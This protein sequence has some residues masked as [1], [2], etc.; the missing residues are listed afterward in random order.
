VTRR[1]T[2]ATRARVSRVVDAS[3]GRDFRRK[4]S[5]SAR[6]RGR[7]SIS[8]SASKRASGVKPTERSYVIEPFHAI[9]GSR[10]AR[11][12]LHHRDF[13]EMQRVDRDGGGGVEAI[14]R[15]LERERRLHAQIATELE[16]AEAAYASDLEVRAMKSRKLRLKDA[17]AALERD[18]VRA[19]ETAEVLGSGAY[20]RIFKAKD[21][22]TG[23]PVA[24]KVVDV[25]DE[26]A[27]KAEF[28]LLRTLSADDSRCFPKPL[29][30][31]R[32]TVMGQKARVMVMNLL[33]ESLEQ[34]SQ[35]VTMGT[36]FSRCTTARVAKRLFTALEACHRNCV[37][38][39]D[40]KPDNLLTE[41]HVGGA[42]RNGIVLVDFGEAIRF[43]DDDIARLDEDVSREDWR[44]T[45]LFSSPNVDAGAKMAP[46]DDLESAI[47]T[48][49]YLR[50]G[51][52]PWSRALDTDEREVD[53]RELAKAKRAV[54]SGAA[55]LTPFGVDDGRVPDD[56]EDDVDFFERVLSHA[57][58]LRAADAPDYD[59]LQRSVAEWRAGS[60]E[61]YEWE[62]DP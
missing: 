38:H 50:T 17:V 13:E 46:R 42:R 8:A 4:M 35:R 9:L 36:G 27:L 51:R 53:V 6:T 57:R 14:E 30:C 23:E 10:K 45:L 56:Y 28:S 37:V 44:G 62:R 58:S 33:G 55:L 32:Q 3:S 24:V 11:R 47:Y 1:M 22:S 61:P 2:R 59:F 43:D 12:A 25:A 5:S 34:I 20:G 26:D 49:A 18:L 40:V 54:D 21:A 7:P 15:A 29:W 48:L 52:L 41:V 19:R 39:G 16:E 31:G 60:D